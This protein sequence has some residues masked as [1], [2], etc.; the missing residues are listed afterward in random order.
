[1]LVAAGLSNREIGR[2]LRVTEGTVRTHL[3]SVFGKLR[4]TSRTELAAAA[5]HEG[6]CGPADVPRRRPS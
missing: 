4:V 2:R 6:V 5:V 3:R 1:M